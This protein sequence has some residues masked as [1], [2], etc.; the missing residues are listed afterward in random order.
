MNSIT[1]TYDQV[2]QPNPYYVV[3]LRILN[4]AGSVAGNSFLRAASV[5]PTFIECFCVKKKDSLSLDR[6]LHLVR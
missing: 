5:D 6:S 3:N 1:P 4:L 2:L